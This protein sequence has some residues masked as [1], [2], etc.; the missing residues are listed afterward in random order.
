M[1][2]IKYIKQSTNRD[3]HSNDRKVENVFF[4]C[5]TS[6]K[7]DNT[8]T[9]VTTIVAVCSRFSLEMSGNP[10]FPPPHYDYRTT[11]NGQFSN[12]Y[13]MIW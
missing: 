11:F 5:H 7:C 3:K 10:P 1:D 8:Q 12:N 2:Q 4:C 9:E 6:N 13:L